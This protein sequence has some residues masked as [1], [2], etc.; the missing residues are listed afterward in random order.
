[1][2]TDILE[3]KEE[4]LNWISQNQSKAFICRQLKCKP[5]TLESYLKKMNIKYSGNPSGKGTRSSG[6]YISALDYSKKEHGV[7]SHILKNKLIREGIKQNCCEMCG[8][9]MWFDRKLPLEL[10][11]IDGNHYNNE[12]NNLMIL[13]PNCHS[14]QDGNAGSNIG[15][16][17]VVL[18]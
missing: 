13:C 1:M 16:Y 15:K 9:S 4:I 2:R 10:H 7:N 12:I 18:E 3:R 6:K 17:A 8:A 5:E 14:V 11:H